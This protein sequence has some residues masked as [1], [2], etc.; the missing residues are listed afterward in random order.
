MDF[1]LEP[2]S[3]AGT[4]FAELAEKHAQEFALTAGQHDRDGSFPD[5]NWDSMRRSGF[6]SGTVPAELGGMGVSVIEDLVVAVSRLARGDGSTAIGAAMHA[7]AFWYL[8]RRLGP[9]PSDADDERFVAG[10]R[11]L[12]RRC[13]RGRAVACVAISEPGTSLG[14]PRTIAEPDGEQ[15]RLTGRKAFCTNSPAAT[16]FLSSVRIPGEGELDRLG[17]ALIPRATPGVSVGADWDALGMRAS[18]SGTVRFDSCLVPGGQVMPV[19]PI[20]VLAAGLL[21]LTMTGALVLAGAFLGLAERAEE[22]VAD[23]VSARRP[24]AAG[25]APGERAAVQEIIG[26]NEVDLAVSRAVLSRAARLLDERLFTAAGADRPYR[27]LADL[28]KEAQCASMA[29]KRAAISIVDRALTASGGSGFLSSH[30]LSRLY[31]DVRAGP[32]MQ[33]FSALDAFEYIGQ[34]RLRLDADSDSRQGV[35]P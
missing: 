32:F 14:H 21:P 27:E 1:E 29:V 23:A 26:H 33:P 24:G 15:Y 16:V 30:P 6:L 13:A 4:R 35:S 3:A 8:A 25:R 31:R 20:G 5:A 10:I 2:V 11:L 7:T 12:L 18:G 28:M 34:V 19:G 22:I 9:A 17:F